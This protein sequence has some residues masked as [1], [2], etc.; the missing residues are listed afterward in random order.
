MVFTWTAGTR[1]KT[2]PNI[3]GAV[4]AELEKDGNLTAANL[5]EASRPKTAPL[6]SEFEWNNTKAAEEWRKHQARNIIHSLVVVTDDGEQEISRAYF[7]IERKEPT[8][9]S[10][11]AIVQNEDK[12]A[13][14]LKQALRELESFRRKY[15][16]IEELATVFAAI[17]EV[18]QW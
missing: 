17:K 14:L 18:N 12:Y 8:Y 9:E 5:V 16:Q 3:A 1:Y 10:I 15:A 7:N 2:D 4:C 13:A 6:H 11:T